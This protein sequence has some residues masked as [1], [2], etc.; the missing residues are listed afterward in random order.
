[1]NTFR[2]RTINEGYIQLVRQL[3]FFPQ[4]TEIISFKGSGKGKFLNKKSR[5]HLRNVHIIF[6]EPGEFSKFEVHSKERSRIMNEYMEKERDLFDRGVID[7]NEM[8]KISNIWK[9]IENPD[10]TINANYGYMTY[11]IKDAGN[12]KYQ[13]HYMS[14]FEWCEDRLSKNPHTLQAVMHFHRP[15]DQY[16]ENLDQPC[17]MY[18][19]YTVEDNKLNF[20]SNMRSNDIIYGMPYNL[21]YFK[22]LQERML[23]CLNNVHGMELSMGYL[24]HNVTSLHLYWDKIHLAKEII[25]ESH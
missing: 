1:M 19:Q 21:A 3:V 18:T 11:H 2:F 5:N 8:G 14:Q 24:H 9:L 22:L 12:D 6:D 4:S 16:K 23:C 13:N 15:K 10:E 17:T 20:H 7:S 25:G